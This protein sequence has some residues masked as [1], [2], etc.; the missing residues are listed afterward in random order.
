M[1][2]LWREAQPSVRGVLSLES[3]LADRKGV[4]PL[5]TQS[6][7]R[8]KIAAGG[9][10]VFGAVVVCAMALPSIAQAPD[11]ELY[12]GI[13]SSEAARR[14]EQLDGVMVLSTFGDVSTVHDSSMDD[15]FFD[16][17]YTG[18]RTLRTV[19]PGG[20]EA[21]SSHPFYTG[22]DSL[23]D[24]DA[25]ASPDGSVAGVIGL[26]GRGMA[27]SYPLPLDQSG[28]SGEVTPPALDFFGDVLRF[29]A[30]PLESGV[31]DE[32]RIPLEG[33]R[34]VDVILPFFSWDIARDLE[35]AVDW[36]QATNGWQG[37]Y[38]LDGYGGIHYVNDGEVMAMMSRKGR[39]Q[40]PGVITGQTAGTE[41]F[42]DIFGF[43]PVYSQDFNGLRAPRSAPYFFFDTARDL[44]VS[45]RWFEITNTPPV[46]A[47]VTGDLGIAVQ[48]GDASSTP[49][50]KSYDRAQQAYALG[51]DNFEL[52]TPIAI[53][54]D[55]GNPSSTNF[56]PSVALTNGYYV[57]IGNGVVFSILE[58]GNGNPIPAAWEDPA[59][60]AYAADLSAD[61]PFF[62]ADIAQDIEILPNNDGFVLL[63]TLGDVRFLPGRGKTL[64]N[65]ADLDAFRNRD[66]ENATPFFGADVARGLK[67]VS[68]ADGKI[69]GYYVVDAFGIIH[70]AGQA[71]PIPQFGANAKL[72]VYNQRVTADV[73]VSPVY[74]PISSN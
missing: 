68:G 69:K 64:A 34:D 13:D 37:Y 28:E 3:L 72:P 15:H 73:E 20:G 40:T 4:R 61:I 59:T 19:T 57:L 62:G 5:K 23:R 31:V 2:I 63:T 16:G 25:V 74:H 65:I 30:R 60:G 71:A 32:S 18:L 43:R 52:S 67:L 14:L 8:K 70:A 9:V 66:P 46:A 45:V 41:L 36:R 7:F 42:K 17:L 1:C 10:L 54:L 51:I 26:D 22:F 50:S 49:L 27:R 56:A 39:A 55:R 38:M 6:E 58:D 21:Y 33:I 24:V 35:L 44:E 53:P 47:K 12:P 11:T 29:N 48:F